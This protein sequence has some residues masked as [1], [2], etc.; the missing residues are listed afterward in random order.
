MFAREAKI[1]ID[2]SFQL[3]RH[4]SFGQKY[5]A[6]FNEIKELAKIRSSNKKMDMKLDYDSKHKEMVL[7][8]NDLVF[9]HTPRREVGHSEKLLS[10]FTGPYRVID[11]RS[12]LN[13]RIQK[14]DNPRIKVWAHVRRLRLYSKD[15]ETNPGSSVSEERDRPEGN[16]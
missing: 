3:P 5:R 7:N 8:I 13:Y 4:F 10:Q 1:P 11:K 15:A 12:D 14:L 6:N 2:V 9:L 16:H